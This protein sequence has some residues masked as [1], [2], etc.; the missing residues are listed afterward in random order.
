MSG[1]LLLP[2]WSFAASPDAC[3]ENVNAVIGVGSLITANRT[4]YKVNSSTNVIEGSQIGPASPQYLAGAAF[5]LPFRNF[6][7]VSGTDCWKQKPW[8]AFVSLKFASGSSSV[9]TG[10]V[11]GVSYQLVEHFALHV[12]YALTPFNEPSS[13][14]KAV[15][16]AAVANSPT[17][18]PTFN[19]AAMNNLKA[20]AFDGFPLQK[21][22][23]TTATNLYNG[24][25]L[26]THYRGGIV[27][28]ITFDVSISKLFGNTP[29][30]AP[31]PAPAPTN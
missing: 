5:Q 10:Y 18:Y 22:N 17:L 30:P 3:S 16:V 24:D 11:F 28:G 12:G 2:T 20:G 23:N 8:N 26:E 6:K 15:A 29:A 1:A 21:L 27:L 7:G 14:F 31:A 25:P 4:D 13:G 9:L 19:A